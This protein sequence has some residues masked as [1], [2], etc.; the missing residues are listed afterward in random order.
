MIGGPIVRLIAWYWPCRW[1]GWVSFIALAVLWIGGGNY[2]AV[3]IFPE[4]PRAE[5]VAIGALAL[6]VLSAIWAIVRITGE[7]VRSKFASEN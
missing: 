5:F 4:N 1:E 7:E 2:I 6:L 3:A